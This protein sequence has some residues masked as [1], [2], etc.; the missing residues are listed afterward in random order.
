MNEQELRQSLERERDALLQAR[1]ELKLQLHLANLQ[2]KEQWDQLERK[3]EAVST[4]LSKLSTHTKAPLDDIN[5]AAR[6]LF[7]EIKT[8]YDRVREQLRG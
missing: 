1:D 2:A 6:S 4:E 8:G 5:K 3:W 7:G